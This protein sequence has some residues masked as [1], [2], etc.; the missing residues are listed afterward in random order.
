MV[1]E[2]LDCLEPGCRRLRR[3]LHPRRRRTC[4]RCSG[5]SRRR[6]SLLGL[7]IDDDVE[8]VRTMARLRAR[9]SG[10]TASHHNTHHSR[11]S[12]RVEGA[13]HSAREHRSHRSRRIGDAIRRASTRLQLQGRRPA[14]HAHECWRWANRRG[15]SS[16]R[17]VRASSR[18][19]SA[20]IPTSRTQTSSPTSSNRRRVRPRTAP[21]GTSGLD[22]RR[23]SLRLARPPSRCRFAGPFRRCESRSTTNSRPSTRTLSQLPDCLAPGGRAAVITFHSGED[24]RASR[25]AFRAGHR[26][27]A[28]SAI[29]ER[30]IRSTKAETFSNRRASSA[31]LRWARRAGLVACQLTTMRRLHERIRAKTDNPGEPPVLIVAFGDSVTQGL[32]VDGE[33]LHDEVTTRDFGGCSRADIRRARSASSTPVLPDRQPA[34]PSHSSIGTSFAINPTSRSLL[35]A[36]TTR[37]TDPTAC[38]ITSAASPPSSNAFNARRPA[39]SC[40]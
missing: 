29:A 8:R 39:T 31:K 20:T 11:T 32:T 40:C 28:F 23:R 13:R 16:R 38:P 1:R 4:E 15:R 19:S 37:G 27:G 35:W 14:R 34:A 3:R 6:S 33:H 17:R 25:N 24:R 12:R 18:A 22:S 5:A 26:A 36:S 10:A 7:D 9:D 21:S 2:V 30:V